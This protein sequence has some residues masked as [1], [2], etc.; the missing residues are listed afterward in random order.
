[1]AAVCLRLANSYEPLSCSACSHLANRWDRDDR[2]RTRRTAGAPAAVCT[3][4]KGP[5]P[6]FGV[7]LG[8]AFAEIGHVCLIRRLCF[9]MKVF[10]GEGTGVD[11]VWGTADELSLNPA[12]LRPAPQ[13][14]CWQLNARPDNSSYS[15]GEIPAALPALRSRSIDNARTSAKNKK[16]WPILLQLV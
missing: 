4:R 9:H 15:N 12:A 5:Y 7:L 1:M 13:V 3:Y 10:F 14:F 8:A 2:V 11:M 16:F 6:H